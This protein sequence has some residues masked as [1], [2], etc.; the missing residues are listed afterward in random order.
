MT[1][2]SSSWTQTIGVLAGTAIVATNLS[3]ANPR[4]ILEETTPRPI[5]YSNRLFASAATE[6]FDADLGIV[7]ATRELAQ[8]RSR[9]YRYVARRLAELAIGKSVSDMPVPSAVLCDRAF[10]VAEELFDSDTPTPSVVSSEDGT[11]LFV[12]RSQPL[13]LEIEIG[14]EETSVWAYERSRGRIWSGRLE[15][16]RARVS[17]LLDSFGSL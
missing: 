10:S 8:S 2:T 5:S 14:P 13:E 16:Q 15:E 4:N 6:L 9:W 17:S 11:V 1:A 7:Y 3:V 12:W